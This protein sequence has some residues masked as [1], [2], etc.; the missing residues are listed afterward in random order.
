[1]KSVAVTTLACQVTMQATT[2]TGRTMR[3]DGGVNGNWETYPLPSKAFE[4]TSGSGVDF[5]GMCGPVTM[6]M[7]PML[8]EDL[9]LHIHLLKRT[10]LKARTEEHIRG[11]A[12]FTTS[13]TYSS[14]ER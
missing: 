1:M 3:K 10:S 2:E 8:M 7:E 14:I 4:K 13:R 6:A 12:T 11:V 5:D 9:Y